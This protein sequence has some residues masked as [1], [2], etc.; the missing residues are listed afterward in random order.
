MIALFYSAKAITASNRL[1]Y[2]CYT[3]AYQTYQDT[4]QLIPLITKKELRQAQLLLPL[5]F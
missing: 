3:Q 1:L 5:T 2:S 4:N